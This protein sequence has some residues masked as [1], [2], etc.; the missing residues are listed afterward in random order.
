[1]KAKELKL[2]AEIRRLR[3]SKG[4]TIRQVAERS[5]LST[6][7]ISQI[8]RDLN[9]PSVA[10]LWQIANALETPIGYFLSER[11]A[12]AVVRKDRRKKIR[13][14]T[15]NV[16]YE[17]LSPDLQG[18]I[19]FLLVNT[20]PG[21]AAQNEFVSHPGEEYGFVI[22]GRLKVRLG[23]E[24]HILEKGDSIRFDSSIPHRFINEGRSLAVSIWAV[25][26]PS[27]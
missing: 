15:S 8:E 25:T 24:E 18:K 22:Q 3:Q 20:Q 6:G 7:L 23:K 4:L 1:M 17:L 14:P 11:E 26:P 12:P 13:L 19:E 10:S 2:G 9:S 16:T 21:E 27:F 5:G